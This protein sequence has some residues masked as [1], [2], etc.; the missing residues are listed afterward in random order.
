LVSSSIF[1]DFLKFFVALPPSWIFMTSQLI[2]FYQK[3]KLQSISYQ[4]IY[5]VDMFRTSYRPLTSIFKK[6]IKSLVFTTVPKEIYDR[7][8]PLVYCGASAYIERRRP[9]VYR[10]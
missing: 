4:N 9:L 10:K 6:H 5:G 8:R 2:F 3:K 7:R 1:S